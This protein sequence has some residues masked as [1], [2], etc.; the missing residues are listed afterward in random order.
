[1]LS[2]PSFTAN[3]CALLN[4]AGKILDPRHCTDKP[5]CYLIPE[6]LK[7]LHHSPNIA[8]FRQKKQQNIFSGLMPSTKTATIGTNSM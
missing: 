2:T 8:I 7:S 3:F 4:R 6:A 5:I 1:M